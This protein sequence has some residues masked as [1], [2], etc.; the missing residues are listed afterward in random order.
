MGKV[1]KPIKDYLVPHVDILESGT[2]V[3]WCDST[4]RSV[5]ERMAF[6]KK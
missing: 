4:F 5:F 6:E 3:F 2:K 1:R